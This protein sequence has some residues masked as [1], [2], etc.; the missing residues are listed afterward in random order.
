MAHTSV[1]GDPATGQDLTQ[2]PDRMWSI[3]EWDDGGINFELYVDPN[4]YDPERDDGRLLA[5][6]R[7]G[8]VCAATISNA[9]TSF[10]MSWTD[11]LDQPEAFLKTQET[12]AATAYRN[13]PR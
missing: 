12:K 9:N 5:I 1:E 2:I 10:T 8:C 11:A 7:G 4:N 3:H 6:A 13:R